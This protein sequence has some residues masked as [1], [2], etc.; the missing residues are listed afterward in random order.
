MRKYTLAVTNPEYWS[1]IHNALIVDSN[2]DGIPDRQVTCS[3][4]KE[5]SPTRG[6]YEL[7][8]EEAAEIATHPHIKWIELSPEHYPDLYPK[9][10]IDAKRFKRCTKFYRTSPPWQAGSN[11]DYENEQNRSNWGVSRVNHRS[12]IDFSA[13]AGACD[14]TAV[15]GEPLMV[16]PASNSVQ[17]D[18]DYQ[19]T[20]KNVDLVIMDTGVLQYHPEFMDA[21]GQSRVRDI[22]L[23]G[24]FYIDPD[25]FTTNNKTYTKSDG[26]IGINTTDAKYWWWFTNNRSAQFSGIGNITQVVGGGVWNYTENNSLGSNTD[27]TNAMAAGH[28]TSCASL[29]AG[30]NF[31]SAFEANIWSI[32]ALSGSFEAE[33]AYDMMKLFHKYKPINP[34]TGKKNPTIVNGSWSYKGYM[35][36]HGYNSGY[37]KDFS[38]AGIA[39]TFA[40]SSAHSSA[41]S[42][43]TGAGIT[44][45]VGG[46]DFYTV[47]GTT[48]KEFLTASHSN[49]TDTAADEMMAEGV[50]FVA[51][52]GNQNQRMG[53][54][55]NDPHRLDYLTNDDP[56]G[57]TFSFQGIS[58]V[59]P[60]GHRD[61]MHPSGIGFDEK[62]DFH[63]VIC[64]G[65]MARSTSYKGDEYKAY[66]SNNGPGI[67]IWAPGETVLAAGQTA[68][69]AGYDDYVRID[70][71]RFYD[72][73]FGGTSAAAP[74]ATG[75]IA[76]YL[77][78]NPDADSRSVKNWV[79]DNATVVGIGTT[80]DEA[81]KQN[82]YLN[83]YG[84]FSPFNDPTTK[85]Y[86]YTPYG[87]SSPLYTLRNANLRGA[88]PR[89]LYNPYSGGESPSINNVAIEGIDFSY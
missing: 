34:E 77:E 85:N 6:T 82:N 46:L 35:N 60:F 41:L 33:V 3:D 16:Y 76:L 67:D 23:D 57:G 27:G 54:G 19:A 69:N 45:A 22:L 89:I 81:A 53:I 10:S 8:E 5:H 17:R 50:I 61:W 30:N 26:R 70:D 24:P 84:W 39:G 71:T 59:S 21:N 66:F 86:W 37:Y 13:N 47:V 36:V 49:S 20:G 2:Q 52:G 62:T 25:Y 72:N 14:P 29:A 87:V 48:Y 64:V 43:I 88:A 42:S 38:F 31:G 74:V 32:N 79:Q 44:A 9:P 4:C 18:I 58:G 68:I 7:T 15:V 73:N 12:V 1:E 78:V 55:A 28:G 80:D 65:A 83:T 75:V 11:P 56:W 51:S 40:T 63:P